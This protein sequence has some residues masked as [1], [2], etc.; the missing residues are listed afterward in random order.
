MSS[1]SLES[2]NLVLGPQMEVRTSHAFISATSRIGVHDS[3]T[4]ATFSLR[5]KRFPRT[6]RNAT[7]NAM[8][9]LLCEQRRQALGWQV[10]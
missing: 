1:T 2:A 9:F 5:W 7:S 4:I 6:S 8:F 10:A 3:S